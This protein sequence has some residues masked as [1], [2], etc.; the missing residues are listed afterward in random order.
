MV[1]LAR[2]FSAALL[3]VVLIVVIAVG[4]FAWHAHTNNRSTPGHIV[5][6]FRGEKGD[7]QTVNDLVEDIRRI[8][9]L[10]ELQPWRIKTLARYRAGQ[11]RTN[12]VSYDMPGFDPNVRLARDERPDFIKQQWGE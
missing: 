7:Q 6:W 5:R 2:Y 4:I 9:S 12:G 10:S 1:P 8:P 11:I 3:L